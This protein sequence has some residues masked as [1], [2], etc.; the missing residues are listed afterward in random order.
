MPGLDL[1]KTAK[2]CGKTFATGASQTKN[3][4]GQDIISIQGDV[5]DDIM[6][7]ISDGKDFWKE[8]PEDNVE[9]V[10]DRKKKGAD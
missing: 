6:E 10:E 3:S 8:V 2:A 1:K 4:Q 5:A 9:I 7:M